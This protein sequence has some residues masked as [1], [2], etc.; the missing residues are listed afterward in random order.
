M[1]ALSKERQ[2]ATSHWGPLAHP[3][4]GGLPPARWPACLSAE[5]MSRRQHD[6]LQG[7]HLGLAAII[8][9]ISPTH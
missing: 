1:T 9:S 5:I 6:T 4:S 7:S 3:G 8:N 2:R